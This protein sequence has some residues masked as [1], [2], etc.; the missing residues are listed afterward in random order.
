MPV[1][2]SNQIFATNI[3]QGT[4]VKQQV[5]VDGE[6]GIGSSIVHSLCEIM[7]TYLNYMRVLCLVIVVI[8]VEIIANPCIGFKIFSFFLQF[9]N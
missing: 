4:S 5:I 2:T 6:G 1:C 7:E 3:L 9:V 8:K